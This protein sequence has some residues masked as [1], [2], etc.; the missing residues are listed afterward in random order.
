MDALSITV[1]SLGR[2][3]RNFLKLLSLLLKIDRV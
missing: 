3:P 2:H 1:E